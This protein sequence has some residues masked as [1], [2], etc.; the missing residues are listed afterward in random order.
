MSVRPLRT[1]REELEARVGPVERLTRRKVR[2]NAQAVPNRLVGD[3]PACPRGEC[4]RDSLSDPER[5][6]PS[7]QIDW[8]RLGTRCDRTIVL[9][10]PSLWRGTPTRVKVVPAVD[11]WDRVDFGAVEESGHHAERHEMSDQT[12]SRLLPVLDWSPAMH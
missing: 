9:I 6:P 4:G 3:V 5:D 12:L 8:T 10:L 11:V 2:E 7:P 1:A